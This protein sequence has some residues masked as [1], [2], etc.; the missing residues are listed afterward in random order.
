ME[1]KEKGEKNYKLIYKIIQN[2]IKDYIINKFISIIKN[3]NE[4]IKEIKKSNEI[5]KKNYLFILKKLLL[6]EEKKKSNHSLSKNI[7]NTSFKLTDFS[8]NSENENISFINN[9]EKKVLKNYKIIMNK[10]NISSSFILKKNIPLNEEIFPKYFHRKKNA[11]LEEK[12]INQS[13]Q[14]NNSQKLISTSNKNSFHNDNEKKKI[15]KHKAERN[16]NNLNNEISKKSI[17][18]EQKIFD[19]KKKNK[20]NYNHRSSFLTNKL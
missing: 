13:L 11:L 1:E 8:K 3:Q 5:L 20:N 6:K 14:I 7:L 9:I 12:E 17:I 4:I 10:K 15:Y 18:N 19:Y 2:E 16:F